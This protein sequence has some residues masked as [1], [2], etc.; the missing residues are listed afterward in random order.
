[1]N[2][3]FD[4]DGTLVDS[5]PFWA[6]AHI[7]ALEKAGI[8]VPADFVKTITPLGNRGASEYTVSL[9]LNVPLDRYL[10]N[11]NSSL[12]EIYLS[13]VT[14]KEGVAEKLRELK[15]EG[16]RLHVLTASPHLYLDGCLKNN[17]VYDLFENV[18]SIDDFG[19]VKSDP[20]IYLEAA[21]RL[22]SAPS[23]CI[24]FDDNITALTTAKKA[25]M[26]T[27]GVFDQSAAEEQSDMIAVA[28]LYINSFTE[29]DPKE[30][31]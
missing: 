4:F 18:W 15:N 13:Q 2:Y 16:H 12:R 19:L 1:M 14:L 31:I 21:Y 3:I 24:F 6:G 30:V 27:V 9:G 22:E 26:K 5:M 29:Y 17:G 23:D 28:N 20:T 10:R 8:E 11:I 7:N 25:G